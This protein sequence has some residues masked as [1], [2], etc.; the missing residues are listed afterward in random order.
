[1]ETNNMQELIG[2]D[3]FVALEDVVILTHPG[4]MHLD[5]ISSIALLSAIRGSSYQVIR[6]SNLEDSSA[7]YTLVLDEL[8][9]TLDHHYEGATQSTISLVWDW[10]KDY[11]I[12]NKKMT[13]IGWKE[14]KK[15]IVDPISHTDL[16]GE[17]TPLSYLTNCIKSSRGATTDTTFKELTD[18]WVGNWVDI[19]TCHAKKVMEEEAFLELPTIEEIQ[20][21]KI[22]VNDNPDHF[23][24]FQ[25]GLGFDGL[26]AR[27]RDRTDNSKLVWNLQSGD[28]NRWIAIQSNGCTFV[29]PNGFLG[30]YLTK[31]D[32]L[33]GI[34]IRN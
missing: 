29:H 15:F 21:V 25:Q 3:E 26:I 30:V 31:E 22:K 19:L 23:I 24:R 10:V 17:M 32:A 28:T 5:E 9:S 16:T 14:V 18:L 13:E 7:K 34:L 1:M 11:L 6:S 20:G 33:K 27:V 4:V 12:S 8:Q 2:F